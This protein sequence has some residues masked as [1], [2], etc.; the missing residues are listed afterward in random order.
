M[1][2]SDNKMTELRV[3][4]AGSGPDPWLR[5]RCHGPR[6][7]LLLSPPRPSTPSFWLCLWPRCLVLLASNLVAYHS[8]DTFA[9]CSPLVLTKVCKAQSA[10]KAKTSLAPPL[11][12]RIC[13][14][15]LID[16]EFFFFSL[17]VPPLLSLTLIASF[18]SLS[19]NFCF[20]FFSDNSAISAC[21][22]AATESP[23]ANA[24]TLERW[25]NAAAEARQ[26]REF[27][28]GR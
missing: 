12:F 13:I 28:I 16:H 17:L 18:V 23:R 27:K 6:W 7:C 26:V 20:S 19:S 21:E 5:E 4:S 9:L 3:R 24:T 1:T 22:T 11:P 14:L 2:E 8:A 25:N 10:S 15:I